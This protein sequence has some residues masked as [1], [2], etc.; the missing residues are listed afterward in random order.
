MAYIFQST[1]TWVW[2]VPYDLRV[3][4]VC[5]SSGEADEV[6]VKS[7]KPHSFVR[8][9]IT[10][11]YLLLDF[12]FRQFSLHR[13]KGKNVDKEK[14]PGNYSSSSLAMCSLRSL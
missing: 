8:K 13:A 12:S 7:F 11:L 1:D 4:E 14:M 9:L 6:E 3:T 10:A 5:S 2:H